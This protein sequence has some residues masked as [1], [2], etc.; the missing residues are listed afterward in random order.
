[1]TD[2]GTH[3]G[4]GVPPWKR[5]DLGDILGN[6]MYAEAVFE[7]QVGDTTQI[8]ER[9]MLGDRPTQD[10]R[11]MYRLVEVKNGKARQVTARELRVAI[12]QRE[13]RAAADRRARRILR[14]MEN[15]Q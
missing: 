3:T 7:R 4:M 5:G 15:A 8:V 1:M 12:T 2:R 11:P 6:H 9:T 14:R 13:V 10:C